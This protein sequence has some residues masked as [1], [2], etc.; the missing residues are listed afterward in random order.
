MCMDKHEEAR[1]DGTYVLHARLAKASCHTCPF[2]CSNK[3]RC[4]D[5]AIFYPG[6]VPTLPAVLQGP[7]VEF[8]RE[9]LTYFCCFD[10]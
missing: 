4:A 6:E 10:T 9:Q 2:A 5:Q 3:Y 7:R 1:L 8:P